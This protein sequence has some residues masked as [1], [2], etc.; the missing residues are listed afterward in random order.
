MRG[1]TISAKIATYSNCH[2]PPPPPRRRVCGRLVQREHM[3]MAHDDLGMEY[4]RYHAVL[5]DTSMCEFT[6]MLELVPVP[7]KPPLL[8]A[9]KS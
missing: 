5:D 4:V 8:P 7:E 9:A 2:H 3:K 1:W 6:A